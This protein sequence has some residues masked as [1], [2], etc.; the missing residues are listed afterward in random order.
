MRNLARIS[1]NFYMK[2]IA[3][4]ITIS[5]LAALL[6]IPAADAAGDSTCWSASRAER[7]FT[8]KMNV[9]RGGMGLGKLEL[10]PELSKVARVHSREMVRAD[11]LHHTPA[12]TLSRRVTNWVTLG[13]NVGVG[14]TVASLHAAFMA[15]PTH[16]DNIV[17]EKYNHV[18]VG[19]K[20]ANG[21]LWV[22]VIFEARTN[23]G[24]TLPMPSC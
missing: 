6:P 24:T 12:K 18:G 17:L 11:K 3:A 19:T 1:D 16:K 4:L 21:K 7:G 10:D 23:P 8:K 14:S 22:T 9:V 13:E 15:S 2:R 5:V 20:K